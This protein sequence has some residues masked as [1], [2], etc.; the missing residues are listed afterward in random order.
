MSK[1][2][3]LSSRREVWRVDLWR[4][5]DSLL[6]PLH[7]WAGCTLLDVG[8]CVRCLLFGDWDVDKVVNYPIL[9]ARLRLSLGVPLEVPSQSAPALPKHTTG[10]AVHFMG[11]IGCVWV[12]YHTSSIQEWVISSSQLVLDASYAEGNVLAFFA[13]CWTCG[14]H[15]VC[16]WRDMPVYFAVSA[17]GRVWPLVL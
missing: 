7:H 12:P 14:D 10:T 3:E 13:V 6:P 1:N 8:A 4:H 11:C 16:L 2:L 17:S 5:Q 15:D 9:N